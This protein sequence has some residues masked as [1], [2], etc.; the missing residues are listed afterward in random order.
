MSRQTY[1]MQ[2]RRQRLHH[3][4]YRISQSASILLQIGENYRQPRY[5]C[6]P[7][8]H[9]NQNTLIVYSTNRRCVKPDLR[10][11]PGMTSGTTL[12]LTLTDSSRSFFFTHL[13]ALESLPVKSTCSPGESNRQCLP[14]RKLPDRLLRR[15]NF[16][17]NS[18]RKI[19]SGVSDDLLSSAV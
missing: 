10:Y 9:H 19:C 17:P 7:I 18:D 8:E 12:N 14:Q 16:R 11:P 13:M 15:Q 1:I 6:F 5:I 4:L 3:V 2:L